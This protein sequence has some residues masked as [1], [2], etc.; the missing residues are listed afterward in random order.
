MKNRLNWSALFVVFLVLS[1]SGVSSAQVPYYSYT[2]DS[3]GN[4]VRTQDA[5]LPRLTVDKIGDLELRAP[6]DIHIDT[7]DNVYI[8][9]TDNK[10]IVVLNSDLEL[11]SLVGEGIL[12]R[13][14]G[15]FVD[16]QGLIYAADYGKSL[17]FQ[18]SSDGELLQTFGRPDSPLFGRSNPYRPLKVVVDRRGNLY[19]IGDGTTDGVIQLSPYGDF[20]GYYGANEARSNLRLL[21]QRTFFT[22]E[23]RA[24]LF[25]NVPPSPTNIAID[26]KGLIYTVTQGHGQAVKK[27]DISGANMLP[28]GMAHDPLFVD[29]YI[30]PIGN[31]FVL[32]QNGLI[33]EFDSEG[34][35]IFI[36]GGRD[37]GRQRQGLFSNPSG[38]AVNSKG[39]VFVVDR[40]RHNIH[41]FSRTEF[42]TQVHH[43]LALYNEGY[44][45]QSQEP[46]QYVLRLNNLFDLAHT[47]MGHGY[48]KLQMYEEALESYE[49]SNNKTGYS[50]AFWEIRNQW[51]QDHLGTIIIGFIVLW[52]VKRFLQFLHRKY[53]IFDP[54]IA[55]GQR[56]AQIK[57]I[58]E[59]LFLGHFIKNPADGFYGI[60]REGKSSNFTATLLYLLFFI[61][62]LLGLYY[63]NFI[64]R[65]GRTADI[66]LSREI[67]KVAVPFA[68]WVISNY[69]VSTISDGEGKFSDVYQGTIYSFAPYLLFN[70][71]VILISNALT[72]NEAFV[73]DFSYFVI[74]AWT[75]G[76]LF[77]MVMETHNF[78]FKETIKNILLTGF[79]MLILMLVVF[80]VY[81]LL[82]QVFDFGFSVVQE[83]MVRAKQ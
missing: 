74:W 7:H 2:E 4:L 79:S 5:Y 37:S 70:P 26:Q 54:V 55:L 76:L 25:R 80:I 83:V 16:G 48:Y 62:W 60:K 51:L 24:R 1:L 6:S 34:N 45:V 43:A 41:V 67:A 68:L 49:I 82:D 58:Q 14:T 56:T 10:R 57:I 27:L 53:G 50:N 29:I 31:I 17:V 61:E 35:L 15:V 32:S 42:T 19:I 64:F 63:T 66:M 40:E 36:F 81:V 21:L 30:G 73:Y 59:L 8:A 38:I 13:P 22:Q 9:D 23:Q 72:Y 75:A 12:Q 39:E 78:E 65:Q 52:M 18:F 47:G 69:L 33:Y 28:A 3:E 77:V 46:W 44:Y 20:L 71:L 11:Q